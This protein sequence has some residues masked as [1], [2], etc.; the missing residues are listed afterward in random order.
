MKIGTR[1][2]VFL[3]FVVV[4]PFITGS[5]FGWGPLLTH[6]G[7]VDT[8]FTDS[9]L[10]NLAREFLSDSQISSIR[11]F[12]GDLFGDHHNEYSAFTSRAWTSSN[13][14]SDVDE[15][16]KL[17]YL[18]HN[19]GDSTVP[20]DHYPANTVFQNGTAQ[21]SLELQVETGGGGYAHSLGDATWS[22][23]ISFSYTGT[24]DQIMTAHYNA[25]RA[26]AGWY[27]NAWN[28]VEWYEPWKYSD[29]NHTAG[30]TGVNQ[31][32]K[33][34]R[35]IFTDYFLSR[36]DTVANIASSSYAVNPGGSVSFSSAGSQDPDSVTWN[37]DASYYNNGGGLS[38]ILWDF[39]NDGTYDA[40]GASPGKSHG[41]L[42]SLV[43]YTEGRTISLR[44]TDNEGKAAYAAA[45][46][47]VYSN[48]TAE[49]NGVY[50][51]YEGGLVQFVGSGGDA[52]GGSVSYAW[53][54][55][56][57]GGYETGGQ[58]PTF[59]YG[60]WAPSEAGHTVVLRVTDNENVTT[61]DT[62]VVRV[63]S[64]PTA[65]GRAQY[66]WLGKTGDV[67]SEW[68]WDNLVDD[69]S[70]DADGGN[71]T[72]WAWDLNND[73]TYDTSGGSSNQVYYSQFAALGITANENHTVT[74]RVTDNEG[75]T[76]TISGISIPILVNPV[77]D[78]VATASAWQ[79]GNS[80]QLSGS[81]YDPDG[82]G[83]TQYRWD[84]NNDGTWDI[85]TS[86]ATLSYNDLVGAGYNLAPSE[87][88]YTVRFG[89]VDNDVDITGWWAGEATDTTT[90]CL[91]SLPTADALETYTVE[92]GSSVAFSAWGSDAD[93][94]GISQWLWDLD[95]DGLYDDFFGTGSMAYADLLGLGLDL[96]EW[97]TIG[98]MVIDNEGQAAYDSALLALYPS[99]LGDA[100]GDGVVDINDL[101]LLASSYGEEGGWDG[102]D[103]TL[104]G[105]IDINDLSVLAGNYGATSSG[106]PT[107][108]PEPTT[109]SLL[110]FGAL[111]VLKRRMIKI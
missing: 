29:V 65:A 53:D 91:Y 41:E 60:T 32:S 26:N 17:Q 97:L 82:G 33:F 86:S 27:Q 71:I 67:P 24:Y 36:K 35:V 64:N 50:S 46:L 40:S 3:A 54:R 2:W 84:I 90:L 61:T 38:S 20:V 30:W 95:G 108:I 59:G 10:Y 52:D 39:N 101:S 34:A 37:S 9:T 106:D 19:C 98:L 15:I 44:V 62:A 79:N 111:A 85:T 12:Q 89:V 104:D 48:P 47:A 18:G 93:G 92:P 100:N 58:N 88:G 81:G 73:G 80:A 8:A 76:K 22:N 75:Q 11:G 78:S 28:A 94:G 66:G 42:V 109:L 107:A 6:P 69:N 13:W 14:W 63:Y 83:I 110:A 51:V 49:A 55:D 21:N 31:G 56:N 4:I 72:T 99:I 1:T 23:N 102:G 68:D 45:T 87:A 16:T 57:N 103:F 25:V 77:A 105:T 70:S 74:L 96:G 5:A 7:I 43:G